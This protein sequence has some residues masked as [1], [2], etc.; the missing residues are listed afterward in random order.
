MA[1][2]A[3]VT[4]GYAFHNDYNEKNAAVMSRRS[5]TPPEEL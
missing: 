3:A 1:L 4:A 5:E 2:E